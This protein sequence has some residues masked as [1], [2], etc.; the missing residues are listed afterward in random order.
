MK[1]FKIGE[2]T[3]ATTSDGTAYVKFKDV[4]LVF[5][6]AEWEAFIAGVKA[7]EFDLTTLDENRHDNDVAFKVID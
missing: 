2:V 1:T 4:A 7:G 5:T 6:H 3:V